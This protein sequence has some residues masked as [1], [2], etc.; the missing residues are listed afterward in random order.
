METISSWYPKGTLHGGCQERQKKELGSW[1]LEVS[2]QKITWIASSPAVEAALKQQSQGD[3][4]QVSSVARTWG[5][6]MLRGGPDVCTSRPSVCERGPLVALS[7]T[8]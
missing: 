5:S 6:P 7:C 8:P 1:G 2:F 3:P 4:V